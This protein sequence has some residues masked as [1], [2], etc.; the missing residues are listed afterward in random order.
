MHASA[1]FFLASSLVALCP[2]LVA[3]HESLSA[4]AA[5]VSSFHVPV[6]R[7]NEL[8]ALLDQHGSIRLDSNADY[9]NKLPSELR[10]SSGQRLLGGWNTRVP[11]IV[12]PGGVSN[13]FI[14]SVRSDGWIAPDIEFIGGAPNNDIEIIGGNSGQGN[15]IRVRIRSGAKINRL[16]LSEYGGLEVQQAKSGY[17]R[18][19]TFTRLLGYWPGPQVLWEGNLKEPSSQNSFLGIASLTPIKDSMWKNAGD[20]LLVGWDCE[21]WNQ[22]GKESA[23]CFSIKG[24]TRVVSIGPSGGT[25]YPKQ[26]GALAS[27]SNVSAFVSWFLRGRGGER[28]GADVLLDNVGS[29]IMVQNA[30]YTRLRESG[31]P[32]GAV[33]LRLFEPVSALGGAHV[34]PSKIA[35]INVDQKAAV[36]SALAAPFRSIAPIKPVRRTIID[37][38]G[39]N[40]RIGLAARPDASARIQA[41]IDANGIVTLAR[42][43]Y[44]LDKPL[45]IG[46]RGRIEGL[47]GEDREGVYLVAKGDFPLIQG[48]GDIA[49]RT[50]HD[51]KSEY[52][53]VINLVLAGL[54]LYG[55]TY[56]IHWSGEQGNFGPGA[57]LAWS[58]FSDLKFLRHSIAGVNVDG[59]HGIDSNLWYHVDF[60]GMPVAF[61]GNGSGVGAGTNYA[62]KQHFLDCQFYDISDTVWHWTSDRPS[63]AQ[64]WKDNVFANIGRLTKTRSATNLL[65]INSVMENVSGDVA[66]NVTDSGSTATYYF[67]MVDSLWRGKGPAV[68]TDTQNWQIGTLFI[69]TEFAQSGG[70][71][72]ALSGEQTLFAWGSRITGSAGV[73]AVKNGLFIH[74]HMGRYDKA[75]QIVEDGKVTTVSGVSDLLK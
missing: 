46:R 67:A 45:K 30:D 8:Q 29:T 1:R 12:I 37:A 16:N 59:I 18:N 61:R 38:L 10:L 25:A 32:A 27:V 33:H 5:D 71:I 7:K 64:V 65:W 70:S 11:R 73:G 26:G 47:I 60:A 69:D 2:S 24:A 31:A 17:V 68:V 13:L 42:G 75:L 22:H 34:G 19:S 39:P 43:I 53:G 15:Q 51:A 36:L 41:E 21:S 74:S 35:K 4:H 28:D 20:L 48:R 3:V 6:S 40:W 66:I 9:R 49:L 56:G 55:G 50:S 72:V 23:R 54:T 57:T 58:Q 44:Y 14:G 52:G 62:D 63:G